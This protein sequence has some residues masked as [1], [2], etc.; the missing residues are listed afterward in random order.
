M[1]RGVIS[2]GCISIS[3]PRVGKGKQ[4]QRVAESGRIPVH[5]PDWIGQLV[6]LRV[7]DM[8][9]HLEEVLPNIPRRRYP[10]ERERIEEQVST[11]SFSL[12]DANRR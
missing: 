6:N 9:V 8:V 3:I 5:A 11:S 4:A 2:I 1:I 12:L 10:A 7:Q